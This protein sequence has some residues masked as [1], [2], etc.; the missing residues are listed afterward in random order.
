M[1]EKKKKKSRNEI[2]YFFSQLDVMQEPV[3]DIQIP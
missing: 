1:E 2:K 3:R